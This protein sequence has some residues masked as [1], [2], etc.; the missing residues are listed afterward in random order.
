LVTPRVLAL[1]FDGAAQRLEREQQAR[2]WQAWHTA[3]L[4]RMKTF[5]ALDKLMG[6]K[7]KAR[8]QTVSEMEAIFAAWAARG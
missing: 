2:A 4:P 3:A 5:P 6:V 7:R 1:V 8:R